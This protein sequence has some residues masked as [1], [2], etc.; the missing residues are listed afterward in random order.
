M[1][2]SGTS[3]GQLDLW[4]DVPLVEVSGCQEWYYARQDDLWSDIFPSRG[5]LLPR[6]VRCQVRV[7]FV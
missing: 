4:S 5:I 1:A 3:S 7:T 6:M 2:K